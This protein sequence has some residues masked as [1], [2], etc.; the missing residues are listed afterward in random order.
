VLPINI[1]LFNDMSIMF[2]NVKQIYSLFLES[3]KNPDN[4]FTITQKL[5][6]NGSS[7]IIHGLNE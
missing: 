5:S 7:K 2:F 6:V 4:Y 1:T 3:R